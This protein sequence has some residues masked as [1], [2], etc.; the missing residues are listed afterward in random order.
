[1][2]QTVISPAFASHCPISRQFLGPWRIK[3]L[4]VL[5]SAEAD[6]RRS[7]HLIACGARG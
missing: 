1:M 5:A 6:A 3:R 7:Q 4:Q 2:P